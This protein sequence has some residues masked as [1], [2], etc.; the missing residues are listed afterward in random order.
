LAT[1]NLDGSLD[2]VTDRDGFAAAHIRLHGKNIG[3]PMG[4]EQTV[5]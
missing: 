2:A 1:R 5:T 4:R 3:R